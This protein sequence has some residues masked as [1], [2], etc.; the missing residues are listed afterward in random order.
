V[1]IVLIV[2]DTLRWDYSH[3]FDWLLQ[4]GFVKYAAW[5]AAPWTL[6]SHISMFTGLYPSE[7]GVHEPDEYLGIGVER[8]LAPKAREAMKALGYGLIGELRDRGYRAVAYTANG[9]ITPQFGFSG[10]SGA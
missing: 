8:L 7:H 6:P 4:Y 1:H 3:H 5:S 9:F 10:T 2:L